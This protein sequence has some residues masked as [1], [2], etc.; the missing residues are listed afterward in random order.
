MAKTIKDI[1]NTWII[2][3]GG[4]TGF[5]QWAA[6]MQ[7]KDLTEACLRFELPI[8]VAGASIMF[9]GSILII[10]SRHFILTAVAINCGL[11]AVCFL[12]AKLGFIGQ[13]EKYLRQYG[14]SA[15]RVAALRFLLPYA[16]LWWSA[17]SMP[18]WVPGERAF[19]LFPFSIFGVIMLVVVC[20]LLFK[21]EAVFGMDRLSF[22]YSYFPQEARLVR[23]QI[24]GFIRHPVYTTWLYFAIG[25]FFIKGSFTSLASVA[26]NIVAISILAQEEEKDIIKYFKEDYLV[27]KKSVPRFFPKKP[28]AFLKFLFSSR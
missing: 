17:A 12:L 11:W 18:L 1:L 14:K 5:R 28:V 25:I 6:Y 22:V 2:F 15:Y 8:A 4:E 20:L 3:K 23:S 16:A 19:H 13:R 27:Y 26:V 10:L 7:F 24:F 9:L 21:I